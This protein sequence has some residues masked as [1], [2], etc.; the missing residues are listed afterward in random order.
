[1]LWFLF[2][3]T[4]YLSVASFVKMLAEEG[5]PVSHCAN[6]LNALMT[7]IMMGRLSWSNIKKK[8]DDN[9]QR[10]RHLGSCQLAAYH[11]DNLDPCGLLSIIVL[12]GILPNFPAKASRSMS[13]RN[14]A[15]A[16]VPKVECEYFRLGRRSTRWMFAP[17]PTLLHVGRRR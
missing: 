6:A 1:M 2:V 9:K 8:L 14:K 7:M 16:Q 13:L 17:S 5:Y 3:F 12:P 15:T 11:D 4:S 10:H